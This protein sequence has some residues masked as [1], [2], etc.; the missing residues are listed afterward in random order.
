MCHPLFRQN[1]YRFCPQF[2]TYPTLACR[3]RCYWGKNVPARSKRQSVSAYLDALAVPS[4]APVRN[5]AA[6]EPSVPAGEDAERRA[7]AQA[8]LDKLVMREKAKVKRATRPPQPQPTCE[9]ARKAAATT[10]SAHTSVAC[11]PRARSA[12]SERKQYPRRL[13][14]CLGPIRTGQSLSHCPL[15]NTPRYWAAAAGG[16]RRP[17]GRPACLW[18]I[19]WAARFCGRHESGSW[20]RAPPGGL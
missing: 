3:R 12:V 6:G 4:R 17:W 10:L 7:E 13:R 18:G 14:R 8:A 9:C 5:A 16:S 2:N 20:Q 15:P 11:C 19:S 1:R